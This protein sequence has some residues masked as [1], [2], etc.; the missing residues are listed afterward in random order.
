MAVVPVIP[1]EIW[2][3]MRSMFC[4]SSLIR[5]S[6]TCK[7]LNT[8]ARHKLS[9]L[10]EA[11]KTLERDPRLAGSEMRSVLRHCVLR[12]M[13]LT[14]P[15]QLA[16]R[17]VNFTSIDYHTVTD[18]YMA[19]GACLV[20]RSA[21]GKSHMHGLSFRG[22]R[23]TL[24]SASGGRLVVSGATMRSYDLRP[25]TVVQVW[26][27]PRRGSWHGPTLLAVVTVHD[28]VYPCVS[29]DAQGDLISTLT[30]FA[31]R[32]FNKC[33]VCDRRLSRRDSEE[34][35]ACCSACADTHLAAYCAILFRWV[36]WRRRKEHLDTARHTCPESYKWLAA[37]SRSALCK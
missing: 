37:A 1:G 21:R 15:L 2:W 9:V 14:I 5:L 11:V 12:G 27:L 10:S 31:H 22:L 26:A 18:L 35:R 3:N 23:L 25:E 16:L 36:A 13:R 4:F 19:T 32:R 20:A 28:R 7:A 6:S 34:D 33:P 29:P 8:L 24:S 17:P 30:D